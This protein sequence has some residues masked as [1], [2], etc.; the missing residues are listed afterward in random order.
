MG[1]PLDALL[2]VPPLWLSAVLLV[3]HAGCRQNPPER[4]SPPKHFRL[5]SRG[6]RGEVAKK[7]EGSRQAALFFGDESLR[8]PG[9][10][11]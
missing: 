2:T 1:E 8:R 4:P 10:H 7:E 6:G 3:A 11:I 9:G 5:N